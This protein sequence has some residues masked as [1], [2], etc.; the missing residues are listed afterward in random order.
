[1]CRMSEY[2][3]IM[4]SQIPPLW[5]RFPTFLSNL[6]HTGSEFLITGSAPICT[7][8]VALTLSF[9]M[10]CRMSRY[11]VIWRHEVLDKET[12]FQI[13]KSKKKSWKFHEIFFSNMA[14]YSLFH[15]G[16]DGQNRFSKKKFPSRVPDLSQKVPIRKAIRLKL[17]KTVSE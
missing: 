6:R 5:G 14:N 15:G 1:M 11:D 2:D 10:V 13:L 9:R 3:V 4:T 16:F 8:S 12:H 17:W 7:S